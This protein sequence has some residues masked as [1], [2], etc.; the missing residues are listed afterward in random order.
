M[1]RKATINDSDRIYHL[2]CDLEQE[3]L[4][5]R[6]FQEIFQRQLNDSRYCCLVLEVKSKIAGVLNLRFE[7]QLHHAAVI[8]EIMEFVVDPTFRNMGLGKQLFEFACQTAREYGCLQIEAACNQ[9]RTETH[10]FYINENMR[11]EHYKFSKSL[12]DHLLEVENDV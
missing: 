12:K 9:Q 5:Y 10:R 7:E 11:N 6:R 4:P 2:I 8:A 1:F 3:E